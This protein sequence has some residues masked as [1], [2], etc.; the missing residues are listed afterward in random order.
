MPIQGNEITSIIIFGTILGFCLVGFVV[1]MVLL[2][3]RRQHNFLR[4]MTLLKQRHEQQILRERIL[5]QERTMTH[6]A[7]E[8]HDGIN[9]Q[10][11]VIK[12]TVGSA[13][14]ILQ[15]PEAKSLLIDAANS[16]GTT[17]LDISRL[18]KTLHTE[19]AE[20]LNLEFSISNELERLRN[21]G[22]FKVTFEYPSSNFQVKFN[23][24]TNIFL[25]RM[26]QESISNI[27]KHAHATAIHILLQFPEENKFE[28]CI[29]DNGV[30]FVVKENVDEGSKNTGIGLINLKNRAKMIGAEIEISSILEQGT[31]IKI[32]LPIRNTNILQQNTDI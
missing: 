7:A 14:S 16:L 30:G 24:A 26:F 6:I 11:Q 10:L 19:K 4:E 3:Q 17:I 20:K 13:R 23:D 29:Q 2:Y 9:Q 15:K 31:E 21:S 32:I 25:F 5:V 22:K 1:G 28:L 8:L 12:L 18:T 27:I